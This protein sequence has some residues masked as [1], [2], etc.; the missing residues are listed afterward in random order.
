MYI[1]DA[2]S[3]SLGANLLLKYLGENG[4]NTPIQ[5]AVSIA[6]GYCGRSGLEIIRKNTFYSKACAKKWKSVINQNR[7]LKSVD[8]IDLSKLDKVSMLH[9]LDEEVTIRLCGYKGLE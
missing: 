4:E 5:C 8:H 6:A 7:V 2:V 9:E 3:F 1:I